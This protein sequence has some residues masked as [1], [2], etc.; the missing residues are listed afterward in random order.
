MSLLAAVGVWGGVDK[1]FT[2]VAGKPLLSFVVD[3]FQDCAGID[4]MVIVLAR[5][6]LERG[7][8][9]AKEQAWAKLVA[10]CPGGARR[11]DSVSRGLLRLVGCEWVVI[12]DGARPC[13]STDLIERGL[14]AA[15]ENGAAIAGVPV[16]DTIKI[17]SRRG[18]VQETP[19]RE[20]LWAIQTP[21]VFRFNLITEAYCQMSAEVTDDA[22][23]LEQLGHKVEVYMGSYQN[24]KVTTPEDLIS[25]EAFLKNRTGGVVSSR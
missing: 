20:F 21:Q 24:I 2:E 23:L 25:V 19:K 8:R 10:V 14:V 9:L 1:V 11:Q 17:V 13:I 15:Q 16:T 12:H 18:Y 3:T 6:N 5:G 4:E 22:M 7:R